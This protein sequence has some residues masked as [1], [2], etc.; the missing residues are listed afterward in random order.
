MFSVQCSVVDGWVV[1]SGRKAR[2]RP[3]GKSDQNHGEGKRRAR[4]ASSSQRGQLSCIYLATI[5]TPYVRCGVI[6]Q[7]G[8]LNL[9]LGRC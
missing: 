1:V 6:P 8:R 9:E 3:L 5:G 7:V 4:G 2:R